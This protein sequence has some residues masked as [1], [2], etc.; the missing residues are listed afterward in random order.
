MQVCVLWPG[1]EGDYAKWRET[2]WHLIEHK[3]IEVPKATGMCQK[4]GGECNCSKK[5]ENNQ[6]HI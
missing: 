5:P 4:T 2:F 6:V 1:L 3:E